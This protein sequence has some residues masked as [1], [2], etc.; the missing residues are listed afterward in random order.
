[1]VS[2]LAKLG[3]KLGLKTAGKTAG[4]TTSKIATKLGFRS[5]AL[6][7]GLGV[8]GLH[9]TL[10]QAIPGL[11]GVPLWALLLLAGGAVLFLVLRGR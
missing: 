7:G 9:A 4:K 10:S 1:M 5:G 11:P 8:A 3:A 6:L 2:W